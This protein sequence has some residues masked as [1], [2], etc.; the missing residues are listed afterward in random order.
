MSL[1]A[2]L[3][4]AVA[5]AALAVPTASP[6]Q[7]PV[8]GDTSALAFA[9]DDPVPNPF[10]EVVRIPFRL[11]PPPAERRTRPAPGEAVRR[12]SVR[13]SVAVYNVLWQRVA[14]A[15]TWEDPP[16]GGLPVRD[17]RYAVPGNHE[18]VWRGRTSGGRRVP[19]GP[20]FVELRVDGR[21]AVRKVL[22]TR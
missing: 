18:V 16:S 21:T 14:W 4:A 12:D 20:Y 3:L 13:V 17:R 1:R 9:L 15:R 11:G 8:A 2:A 19:S 22:L 7:T 10:Q 6:A 5:A